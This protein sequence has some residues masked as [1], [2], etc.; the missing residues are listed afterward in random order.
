MVCSNSILLRFIPQGQTDFNP[1]GSRRCGCSLKLVIF[2]L[3]SRTSILDISHEIAYREQDIFWANADP[4]L[5]RHIKWQSQ[6]ELH[7]HA[8]SDD[9]WQKIF[10]RSVVFPS[11]P[12]VL[13][14][15]Q[16][17]DQWSSLLFHVMGRWNIPCRTDETKSLC[18]RLSYSNID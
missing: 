14:I 17:K 18:H 3:I 11:V 2:Q 13:P 9:I 15:R 4:D 1:P 12:S 8:W 7:F 5:C 10:I 16:V 6:N